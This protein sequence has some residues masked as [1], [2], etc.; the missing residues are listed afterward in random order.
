MG[1]CYMGRTQVLHCY[2]CSYEY[3]FKI[4]VNFRA[5]QVVNFSNLEKNIFVS[6]AS[7]ILV[8]TAV[9]KRGSKQFYLFIYFS[10]WG[11][12]F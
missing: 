5:S 9:A 6:S 10:E 7:Y 11:Y 3:E 2:N 1:S 4:C 8:E 12:L